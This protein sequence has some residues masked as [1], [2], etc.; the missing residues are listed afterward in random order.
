[1]RTGLGNRIL[2]ITVSGTD[3][4]QDKVG[5]LVKT[6]ADLKGVILNDYGKAGSTI[7]FFFH[8]GLQPGQENCPG[9]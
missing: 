1:M 6:D 7:S 8:S 5:L 2:K 9:T 4:K 3:K